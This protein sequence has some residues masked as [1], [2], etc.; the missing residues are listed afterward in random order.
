MWDVGLTHEEIMTDTCRHLYGPA[1]AEM[2]KY[3]NTVEKAMLDCPQPTGNWGFPSVT[4]VFTP[5]YE[6]LA[7]E[8]IQKSTELARQDGDP[9]I[10]ARV[11]NQQKFWSQARQ[12]IAGQRT[13]RGTR[14][15]EPTMPVVA[16]SHEQAQS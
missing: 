6:A 12:I 15:R 7:E 14:R 3:Y 8:H 2:W 11:A 16:Q 4:G 10:I 9:I 1:A 5:E 13:P